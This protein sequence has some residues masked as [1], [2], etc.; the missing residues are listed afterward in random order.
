[1]EHYLQLTLHIKCF[2][3]K[4]FEHVQRD[5]KVRTTSEDIEALTCLIS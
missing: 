5:L 2:C 4:L 3:R 1:M